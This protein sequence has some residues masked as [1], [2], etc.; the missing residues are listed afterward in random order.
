MILRAALGASLLLGGPLAAQ[1]TAGRWSLQVRGTLGSDRGDLRI[2]GDSARL[3]LES[4]DTAWQHLAITRDGQRITFV[5]PGVARFEGSA[6]GDLMRGT[7]VSH[8]S[9]PGT[10]EARRLPPGVQV[11]PVRPRVLVHQLVIGRDDSLALFSDLWRARTLSREALLAEHAALARDA[12]LPVGDLPSIVARAQPMILGL[13]ATGRAVA[14]RVLEGIAASP[15]AD[16]TFRALFRDRDGRWRLDLHDVAWAAAARALGQREVSRDTVAA[17]LAAI[18]ALGGS[19]VDSL[20]VFHAAWLLWERQRAEPALVRA[21]L[22]SATD[23]RRPGQRAVRALMAGYDVAL[24]WWPQAVAWLMEHPWLRTGDTW[25]APTGLVARFW[26]ADTLAMPDLEPRFF[27]VVQAVPVIGTAA[28]GRDL[29]RPG[30]AIGTEYLEATL[31]RREAMGLWR[32]LDFIEPTP[33]RLTLGPQTMVLASPA[34]ITRSRLGGFLAFD[35]AIRIEPGIMPVFAVG[36]VVHE[37]QH[38]LFEAARLTGPDRPGI[39]E[40][41]WGLRVVEAD[42]WLGEGA[43]EWA[44]EQVLLPAH[45]ANPLFAA[46]EAE[47]RLAIGTGLPDDT[48]VLGYLLVRAAMNRIDSAAQLRRLLVARLHDPVGMA[49]ALGLAGPSSIR[50]PRPNT[51]LVIP[52]VSFLLDGGVADG[53]QRRLIVPALPVEP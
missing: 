49:A 3:L 37:W 45:E 22:D 20:E 15:A 30:N 48:H 41:D 42:P 29:M 8:D 38:L 7:V 17:A 24:A 11:W 46:V 9:L 53:I 47:K 12:G 32:Q 13:D 34:A 50:I 39:R 51:L 16:E 14:R 5:V 43:A 26:E 1:A 19:D 31:G 18:G 33:L 40:A 4:R 52:E 21:L 44:T 2:A 27:G 23:A 25:S 28:L 10:W 35:D 6:S 36:T